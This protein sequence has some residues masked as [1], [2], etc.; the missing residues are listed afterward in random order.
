MSKFTDAI[1]H[2]C[3]GLHHINPGSAACCPVCLDEFGIEDSVDPD[4][5]QE[6]M[7]ECDQSSFS[8]TACCTCGSPLCG[9]RSNGHGFDE[10]GEVIHL[11]MCADCVMYFANGDEPEIWE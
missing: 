5:A 8:W 3:K 4:T 6:Q 7:Y 11:S 1:E 9:D 10:N 2:N